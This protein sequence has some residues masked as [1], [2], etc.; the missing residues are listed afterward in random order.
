VDPRGERLLLGLRA[1]VV[2]GH[3]LVIPIR[4]RDKTGPFTADNLAVDDGTAIR[5]PL[6]GDGIRSLEYDNR[7]RSFKLI[8]A[9]SLNAEN[10]DFRVIEW[11]GDARSPMVREITR[12]PRQMKPEGLA[13]GSPDPDGKAVVVFDTGR[14]T[15]MP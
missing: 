9:A 13:F 11:N 4:L 14:Y 6:S 3:A 10:R 7:T 2:D 8:A 5:L 1:P 15:L 12:M